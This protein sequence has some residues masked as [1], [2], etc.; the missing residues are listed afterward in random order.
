M[1]HRDRHGA[2]RP[3]HLLFLA[4]LPPPVHGV[5]MVSKQVA[6]IAAAAGYQV[7]VLAI[8]QST[9]LE[10]LGSG[11][12]GKLVRLLRTLCGLA[13][14]AA[15]GRRADIAYTTLSPFGPARFRD[16]LV[17]LAGRLGARRCLVHLHAEGLDRIVAGGDA[18]N[19]LLRACLGG[20]ELIAITAGSAAVGRASGLFREVWQVPNAVAT[21]PAQP[22]RQPGP[23]RILY[24]SNL[25]PSKGVREAVAAMAMLAADG[26]AF[27]GRIIGGPTAELGVEEVGRL[28]ADA[29]LADRVRVMG[30]LFGEEKARWLEWADVLTYPSRHDHAPLV[31]LEAMAHGVVPIVCDTG[32]V[33]ELP[34]AALSDNIVPPGLPPADIA[35]HM[36]D[37]LRLYAS[38]ALILARDRAA[39]QARHGAAFT[40]DRFR[41]DMLAVLAGGA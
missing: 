30:P 22:A 5:T 25:I 1:M 27:E 12:L 19:R 9:R 26:H 36:R 2:G 17:V 41:R 21:P 39:A 8:G 20:A 32:G 28:V 38:D 23:L 18:G 24:L 35:A 40:T 16:G 15:S 11:R 13:G 10:Q 31:V 6:E 3:T 14:R 37:R 33:A 34:G 4:P 29:G 7:E